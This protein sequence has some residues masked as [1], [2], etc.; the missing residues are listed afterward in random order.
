[1][2]S[3]DYNPQGKCHKDLLC[4]IC[5]SHPCGQYSL[6]HKNKLREMSISNVYIIQDIVK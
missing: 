1:M 6:K 5:I 3:T 2:H 4:F